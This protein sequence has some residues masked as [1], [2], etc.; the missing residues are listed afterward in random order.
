MANNSKYEFLVESLKEKDWLVV[1]S[2]NP[3]Q[4]W[5]I[6]GCASKEKRLIF[7]NVKDGILN[8]SYIV[9]HC[10]VAKVDNPTEEAIL[11]ILSG[12]LDK[13]QSNVY[14]AEW[15]YIEILKSLQKLSTCKRLKVAALLVRDGRIVATGWN[16]VASGQK[17]C[18]DIFK[19]CEEGE[20][21]YQKHHEFSTRYELHAEQNL[22]SFCAKN[23]IETNNTTIYLTHSPCIH[24]AK[25]LLSA[26]I[27]EVKFLEMY[28]RDKSGILLLDEN[29]TPCSV[30]RDN[31]WENPI[32]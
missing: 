8:L 28:D 32:I 26:G 4:G 24:C 17:H 9:D 18:E 29:T 12:K 14:R 15:S 27:K 19:D 2:P 10:H 5:V 1:S 13:P 11:D 20:E 7:F 21:F 16:G 25:I 22:I 23:G 3:Q 31:N 30:L 6:S